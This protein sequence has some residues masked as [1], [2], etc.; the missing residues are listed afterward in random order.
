MVL[1]QELNQ[2]KTRSWCVPLIPNNIQTSDPDSRKNQGSNLSSG[3]KDLL[4]VLSLFW[5]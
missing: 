1:E 5:T 4:C 3:L 2:A